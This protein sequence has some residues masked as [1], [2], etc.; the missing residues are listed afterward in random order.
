MNLEIYVFYHAELPESGDQV[1][2]RSESPET[3]TEH[4]T[5]VTPVSMCKID[6]HA[7]LINPPLMGSSTHRVMLGT[8]GDTAV[9]LP[10][11]VRGAGAGREGPR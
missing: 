4:D 5:W 7:P 1:L 11:T 8:L 3:S 9:S 10:L 2:F 6:P